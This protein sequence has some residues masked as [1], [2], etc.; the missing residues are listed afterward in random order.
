MNKKGRGFG[1]LKE[2]ESSKKWQQEDVSGEAR[3]MLGTS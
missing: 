3:I 2:F 1:M